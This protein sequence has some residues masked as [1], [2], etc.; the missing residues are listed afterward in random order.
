MEFTCKKCGVHYVWAYESDKHLGFCFDCHQNYT[1][2]KIEFTC[3]EC[4]VHYVWAYESDKH[5][6]F[7]F[8]C[9]RNMGCPITR[10]MAIRMIK[11]IASEHYIYVTIDYFRYIDRHQFEILKNENKR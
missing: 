7:C 4:G 5:L 1:I 3:K 8:D 11:D 9:H 2:N 10:K 6:G